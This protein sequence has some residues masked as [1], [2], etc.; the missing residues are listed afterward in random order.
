MWLQAPFLDCI[1]IDSVGFPLLVN[2][3]KMG[4]LHQPWH[5]RCKNV[6]LSGYPLR[7][8]KT[9]KKTIYPE[10]RIYP[11]E[12]RD[13]L[14]SSQ[15]RD[16]GFKGSD[17]CRGF[18]SSFP[19]FNPYLLS[20]LVHQTLFQFYFNFF[21]SFFILLILIQNNYVSLFWLLC[22]VDYLHLKTILK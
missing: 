8:L 21:K 5:T 15:G 13:Y 1:L 18:L 7:K 6:K 12:L 14:E 16:L 20:A 9:L 2:K 4:H 17:S 11:F 22:L 19:L 10:S 3:K